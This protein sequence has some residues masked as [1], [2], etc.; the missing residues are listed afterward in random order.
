MMSS[1]STSLALSDAH[2][3]EAAEG[4]VT[5]P[6][7]ELLS[8]LTHLWNDKT[9]HDVTF[10]CQGGLGRRDLRGGRCVVFPHNGPPR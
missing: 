1:R 10:I 8:A 3:G 7:E 2:R 6:Q 4:E 5:G 9:L